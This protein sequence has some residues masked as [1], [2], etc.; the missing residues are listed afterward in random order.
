MNE[1]LHGDEIGAALEREVADLHDTPFTLAGVRG[2]AQRIQ[3]RR[4]GARAAAA[5]AL[6]AVAVPAVLLLGGDDDRSGGLD[7]AAP[8]SSASEAV[9]A[10]APG[11]S[12]LRDGTVTRPDGSTVDLAIGEDRVLSFGVLS[13]GR[14]VLTTNGRQVVQ[15][16]GADGEPEATYPVELNMF[17]MSA[18]GERATW[19]DDDRRVQ[20]L[21]SGARL[22]VGL[23]ELP[24]VR[25]LSWMV[26]AV[27]GDE[28]SVSGSSCRV[29]VSTGDG[30]TTEVTAAGVSYLDA[31]ES[32]T[33][34]DVSPD[35]GTWAVAF[36]AGKNEQFG[37][38][39]LYDVAS[40]SVTARTCET[41]ALRFAP[42]GQ[43]LEGARGDNNMAGELSVLDLDLAPLLTYSPDPEVVSRSAWADPETLLVSISSFAG[44]WS[45]VRVPIDGSAPTTVLGPVPGGNPEL[46]TEFLPSL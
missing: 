19:I 39:G 23:Q 20:V 10:W 40:D 7:P 25:Y 14:F 28:C 8:T 12:V 38:S 26:D 6:A 32:F 16:L 44:Q 41:S 13:D 43:H 45:L 22:P 2:R 1:H 30:S 21:E 17:E 31:S 34:D 29:L 42:D 36:P 5:V 9:D 4:H 46:E 37:C 15:V 3:R 35:G 11:A 18:S 33:V 24:R 27:L